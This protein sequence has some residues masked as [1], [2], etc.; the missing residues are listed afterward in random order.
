M[1]EKTNT[2]ATKATA[3]TESATPAMTTENVIEAILESFPIGYSYTAYRIHTV[4]NA[5]FAILEIDRKIEPQRMYQAAKA[6]QID[7]VKHL[8]GDNPSYTREQVKVYSIAF[9][10]GALKSGGTSSRV[11]LKSLIAIASAKLTK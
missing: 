4:I 10:E 1:S 9:I 5:A 8:K 3:T 11:E 7:G 6:G 2:P